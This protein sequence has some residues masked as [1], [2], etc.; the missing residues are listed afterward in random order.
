ML[1]LHRQRLC[2]EAWRALATGGPMTLCL[3]T[4]GAAEQGWQ[5]K[6]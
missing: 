1:R 2:C 3:Q 4:L 6:R 5:T